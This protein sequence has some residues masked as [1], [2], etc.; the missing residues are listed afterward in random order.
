MKKYSE[1]DDSV[2]A[3]W[4]ASLGPPAMAIDAL[5]DAVYQSQAKSSERPRSKLR[6]RG[7][8]Q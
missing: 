6:F 5:H 2:V 1:Y 8:T 7:K 4:K 3:A